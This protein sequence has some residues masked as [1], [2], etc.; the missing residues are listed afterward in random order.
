MGKAVAESSGRAR[1]G[2]AWNGSIG[3]ASVALDRS[4]K[5]E[6]DWRVR[7][8]RGGEG[9]GRWG[10]AR[11]DQEGVGQKWQQ[12]IGEKRGGVIWPGR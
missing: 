3:I 4:G 11:N 2:W 10:T 5:A 9:N 12:W 8:S 6:K 7:E 1:T